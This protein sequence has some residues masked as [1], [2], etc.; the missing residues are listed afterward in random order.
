MRVFGDILGFLRRDI[1]RD[2]D[3]PQLWSDDT[4]C[5][6]IAQAHDIFAERTLCIRDSSSI[7]ASVQ[8]VEGVDKYTLH[9]TVIS[10]LSAKVEGMNNSLVRA[11]SA[12]FD[13]YVPPPDTV[14]WL[15]TINY[16]T[17]QD[18]TPQAFALDDSVEGDDGAAVVRF[19]PVPALA[20]DGKT[21]NL[22]VARLPLVQ[23]NM[24]ILDERPECPRQS[25]MGLA[26]GAAAF[27]YGLHDSDGNDDTRAD[28]QMRKF[29]QY[30]EDAKRAARHKMFAP[31]GWGF[32]RGGFT[33]SR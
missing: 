27:A 23:C 13:G 31:L 1:L 32:G 20:D 22:R 12:A 18:G 19:W 3:D 17:A 4:L 29:E 28:K 8:L 5:E 7:A 26:H 11:G 9:P 21:V 6:C 30:V 15:E 24:D 14:Q 2:T 33:H 10:V 16:G 25:L